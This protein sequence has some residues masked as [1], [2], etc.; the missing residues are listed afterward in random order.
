MRFLFY[1]YLVISNTDIVYQI[2]K[3][4]NKKYSNKVIEFVNKK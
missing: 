4:Y 3:I 2:K 1:T